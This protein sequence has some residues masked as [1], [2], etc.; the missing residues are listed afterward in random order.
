MNQAFDRI[1]VPA[2]GYLY[3]RDRQWWWQTAEGEIEQTS[4]EMVRNFL[5]DSR[6]VAG[7][8]L[9]S[10]AFICQHSHAIAQNL[11]LKK[12]SHP[13]L[14]DM[15]SLWLFVMPTIP[16]PSTPHEQAVIL[17]LIPASEALAKVDPVQELML[18]PQIM[19]ALMHKT[20]AWK[21]ELPLQRLA[22]FL[23]EA[24]WVFAPAILQNMG[25]D[26]G[27]WSALAQDQKALAV[28]QDLPKWHDETAGAGDLGRGISPE[29]AMESLKAILPNC[30][31]ART[32]QQRYT[33]AVAQAFAAPTQGHVHA[34]TH[35]LEA[36]TGIGKTLGYVAPAKVWAERNAEPVW[37][38][39]YSRHLQDQISREARRHM[40]AEDV[41]IL[42]GRENYVCLLNY[43]DMTRATMAMPPSER[44]VLGLFARW[45]MASDNGIMLGADFPAWLEAHAPAA[46]SSRLRLQ[47]GDCLFSSCPLYQQ[48]FIEANNRRAEWAKLVI[49][50]HALTLR[51]AIQDKLPHGRMILDEA[52]Q[53]FDAT[54]SATRVRLGLYET[55]ELGRWLRGA[56]DLRAVAAGSRRRRRRGLW[57]RVQHIA[58]D[59]TVMEA[60]RVLVKTARILPHAEGLWSRINA[61]EPAPEGVCEQFFLHL[62]RLSRVALPQNDSQNNKA[63]YGAEMALGERQD[64]ALQQSSEE[65]YAAMVR[66]EQATKQLLRALDAAIPEAEN[67]TAVRSLLRSIEEYPLAQIQAW[68]YLLSRLVAQQQAAHAAATPQ[69]NTEKN[70]QASAQAETQ[71]DPPLESALLRDFSVLER[72]YYNAPSTRREGELGLEMIFLDPTQMLS[73]CLYGEARQHVVLTSASLG[74]QDTIAPTTPT[75]QADSTSAA[76]N[77]ANFT[78]AYRCTG[79]QHIATLRSPQQ[80][81][82]ASPYDYAHQAQCLQVDDID[83][84]DEHSVYA[85][86]GRLLQASQGGGLLLFNA[87]ARAQ[88]CYQKLLPQE[89]QANRSLYS[90]HDSLLGNRALAQVLSQDRDA[91]L[92]GTDAF[93]DG[94]DIPGDSLRLVVLERLPW[95]RPDLV[96]KARVQ[97]FGREYNQQIT[98]QRLTQAF[99][100]L[101]RR[102]D[103]WGSFV[104][105]GRGIPSRVAQC[106]PL[107]L[108]SVSLAEAIRRIT[109]QYAEKTNC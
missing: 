81:V 88:Q 20:T 98:R 41:V 21:E 91:S 23:A 80:A 58:L 90:Q 97:H 39:T 50:N 92:I 53:L 96:H 54:D 73:Q 77:Q 6:A 8:D 107:P 94:I 42:K 99:G 84:H 7:T 47:H 30:P 60:V 27:L 100:R 37:I 62:A 71:L 95:P 24:G 16:F 85:A 56:G 105:F 48:C 59:E 22:A 14:W 46:L 35:L 68:V 66:L 38:S 10:R 72:V 25:V 65:L 2:L 13:A 55:S 86:I 103:D 28:H 64:T 40:P 109:E 34:Q 63:R 93:R 36:G 12:S 4:S 49:S 57:Q 69:T 79:V 26:R 45:L 1:V 33:V 3:Y 83:P 75:T 31:E 32:G 9:E 89:E 61:P 106:L 11:R 15:A 67:P 5:T 76:A 108:K 70:T 102:Q 87:I 17:D 74:L 51:L 29:E 18:M 101:I 44:V 78:F 52:H 43:E 104:I 82:F 19:R